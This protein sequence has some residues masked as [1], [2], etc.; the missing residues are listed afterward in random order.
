MTKLTVEATKSIRCRR[1]DRA[2][3]DRKD[4]EAGF[5]PEEIKA[6]LSDINEGNELTKDAAIAAIN[7]TEYPSY[8]ALYKLL[9]ELKL[10]NNELT[11][12]K[13]RTAI[14]CRNFKVKISQ[15]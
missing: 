13:T 2:R 11:V 6:L 8:K 14:K 3:Y 4:K 10:C 12:I 1:I 9:K 5:N 7:D 15:K